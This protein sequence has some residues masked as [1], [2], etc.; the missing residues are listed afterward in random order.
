IIKKGVASLEARYLHRVLRTLPAMRKLVDPSV[1]AQAIQKHYSTELGYKNQLLDLLTESNPGMEVDQ[2]PVAT[3]ETASDGPE[4]GVFLSLL[5]L[6]H[7]L[8]AKKFDAGLALATT[9]ATQVMDL[10]RRTLDPLAAKLFFYLARFYELAG[11]LAE[12]RPTLLSNLRTATIHRDTELQAALLN[13]SLRNLIHFN[14]FEQAEKLASKTVF[15]EKASNSQTVRYMYYL[16]H[17]KAIQLDYTTAHTYLLQAQRKAPQ[18]NATVGFQQSV[19][20]LFVI[21]QLLMGEIPERSIFRQSILRRS[22]APYLAITQAVRVGDLAKF[23]QTVAQ[24]ES[25]F[26]SDQTYTL[27]MRLRHNVIKTGIRMISLSY[28]RISLRDICLKLHLDSEEDA[29]YIVG[30]AIRDGVIDAVIDHEH[31]FIQSKEV[32]DVYSTS[33]PQTAFNQRIEFCLNLYNDSVKALRFPHN[34]H[35]KDLEYATEVLERERELAKEIAQGEF[36]PDSDADMGL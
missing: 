29:E 27:I 25:R 20:K 22:L 26:R 9:L 7:L 14:L 3:K 1:L 32:V 6:V 4:V 30:K 2:S 35:Q 13:L 31:G 10:N 17:I 16:G 5:V 21:V 23:Q 11:R 36:D 15:P 12:L 33:E 18:S 19:H 8:D 24:Y 28:L 34:A